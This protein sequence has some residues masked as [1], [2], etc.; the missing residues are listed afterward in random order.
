MQYENN[1]GADQPVHQHSLISAFVIRCL[2]RI[3][4]ILAISKI[5][6]LE[7]ISAAERAFVLPA[8]RQVFSFVYFKVLWPGQHY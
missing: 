8:R 3:I 1:K 4:P 5:S 6:R 7:L 2:D